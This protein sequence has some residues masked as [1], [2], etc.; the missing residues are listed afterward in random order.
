MPK[1]GLIGITAVFLA[2]LFKK[3]KGEF[4]FLIA[5]AASVIIFVYALGRFQA[6]ADFLS[7]ILEKLPI[8]KTYLLA[9][10]KMLGITYIA[11]FSVSVCR[12]AGY[13]SV[14]NQIEIFAKLSIIAL[15]LPQL[16]YLVTTLEALT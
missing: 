16:M 6:V 2:L 12:E 15:G 13:S 3:E 11:D 10:L 4:S 8:E 7:G 5:V 1:I 9:L 14:G